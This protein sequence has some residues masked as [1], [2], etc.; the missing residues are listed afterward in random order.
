MIG[1][2]FE[3]NGKQYE[4]K[5]D[6]S[7]GE[8]KKISKLGNT[9]QSLTKEYESAPEEEKLKIIEK[10]SKTTDDQLQLIGDFIESM[11]G[12]TQNDIDCMSLMDAIGLFNESFTISTSIKKKSETTL[13]SQSL[14]TTPKIQP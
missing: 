11:L 13:E 1:E 7:F 2:K 3:Y 6:V 10:F 14:Q 4:I 5:R 12:L 8:Y 9:L